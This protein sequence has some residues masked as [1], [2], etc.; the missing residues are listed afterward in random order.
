MS[1]SKDSVRCIRGDSL[2]FSFKPLLA[3][4]IDLRAVQ[5]KVCELQAE[6]SDE[7]AYN[8]RPSFLAQHEEAILAA[9]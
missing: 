9:A 1:H 8:A 3:D 2:V 6:P 7:R 4:R 5:H